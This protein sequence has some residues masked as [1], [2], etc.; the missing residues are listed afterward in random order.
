MSMMLHSKS[1]AIVGVIGAA[2]SLRF[3]AFPKTVAWYYKCKCG[4]IIVPWLC[5]FGK[6]LSAVSGYFAILSALNC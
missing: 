3:L 1:K 4:S 2:D 5:E 6:N